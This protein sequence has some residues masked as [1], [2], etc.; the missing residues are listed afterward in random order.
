MK[1]IER[2]ITREELDYI[3]GDFKQLEFA[4]GVPPQESRRFQYTLEDDGRLLGYV[5]GITEH[6]YFYLTD[7][8][9]AEPLRRRGHGSKLLR[10]I[11][12]R[13]RSIGM[14]HIYLWTAGKANEA[15]YEANGYS[16]FTVLEGKFGVEGYDQSGYRKKL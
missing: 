6:R 16:C 9:I 10:I 3:C 1:I 8:W 4:E 14:Q 13:A 15:F 2:D 5:S 11:E 12:D 7:L